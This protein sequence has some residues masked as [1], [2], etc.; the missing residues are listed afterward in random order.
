MEHIKVEMCK[1]FGVKVAFRQIDKANTN[2]PDLYLLSVKDAIALS[3]E[4]KNK[5]YEIIDEVNAVPI[6]PSALK[7]APLAAN[8]PPKRLCSL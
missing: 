4:L 1:H 6:V 7:V 5:A 2:N 3:D 8:S